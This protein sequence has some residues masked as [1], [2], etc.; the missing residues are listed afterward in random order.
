MKMPVT[1]MLLATLLIANTQ[2][3]AK[4]QNNL[5]DSAFY[6]A[7][8]YNTLSLYHQTVGDQSALLNGRLNAPYPFPFREGDPYFE[9]SKFRTG[10]VTYDGILY[11]NVLLL[12]DELGELLTTLAPYGR[13]QFISEKLQGFSIAGS[14]FVRIEKDSIN[15]M[16]TG[17]YQ[18]LYNGNTAILKKNQKTIKEVLESAEGVI[19]FIEEK[20]YFYLK[21]GDRFY[22]IRTKSELFTLM[23]DHKKEVQQFIKKNDLNVKN[24]R[25]NTLVKVAEYYD[26]IS[27]DVKM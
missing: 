23:Q 10:T 5:S 13:M 1:K 7:A 4:A 16:P 21:K 25:Q 9:T 24:D 18:Q 12:Y 22:A 19:R 11:E 8:V 26:Q 2:N 3:S 14:R 15:P 27:S 20:Q 6:S 17:F